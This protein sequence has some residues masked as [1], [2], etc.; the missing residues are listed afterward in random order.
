MAGGDETE[1]AILVD[2]P[3][4][5]SQKL[6]HRERLIEALVEVLE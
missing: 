1:G 3:V 2:L 5:Q 6:V 4:K